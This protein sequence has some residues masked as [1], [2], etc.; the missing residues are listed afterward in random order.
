MALVNMGGD[1]RI[2]LSF[3][4]PL[5]L[6]FDTDLN[7]VTLWALFVGQ[8]GGGLSLTKNERQGFSHFHL[9]LLKN[10]LLG[11]L[12]FVGMIQVSRHKIL[13]NP[14]GIHLIP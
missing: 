11:F 5:V 12:G 6:M 1:L 8:W 3:H 14:A 2:V 10:A 13:A 7:L 4:T 9:T